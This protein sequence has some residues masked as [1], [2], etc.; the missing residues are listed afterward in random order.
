[1]KVDVVARSASEIVFAQSK[2]GPIALSEMRKIVAA[3][4]SLPEEAPLSKL[5][6]IVAREFPLDSEVQRRKLEREFGI[7]IMCIQQYQVLA[8]SPEYRLPLTGGA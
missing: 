7:A 1:M 2:S 8:A 3:I 5:V 6:A 4:A